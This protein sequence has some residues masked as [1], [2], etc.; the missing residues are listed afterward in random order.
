MCFTAGDPRRRLFVVM[1][2][3]MLD[4]MPDDAVM[5][6]VMDHMPFV[7][8]HMMMDRRVIV[9]DHLIGESSRRQDQAQGE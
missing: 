7:V 6:R 1:Q 8:D 2:F 3:V 5:H 9:N 4:A